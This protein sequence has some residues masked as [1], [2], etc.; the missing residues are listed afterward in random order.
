MIFQLAAH[1]WRSS[2]ASGN[3][4]LQSQAIKVQNKIFEK[5][6]FKWI[7]TVAENSL[8]FEMF[9]IITHF[10]FYIGKLSIKFVFLCILC[11]AQITI[12]R[13]YFFT[14]AFCC[15]CNHKRI[16]AETVI[17]LS[18][19]ICFKALR[20]SLVIVIVRF[21]I[22]LSAI[23]LYLTTHLLV[24]LCNSVAQIAL[25][26]NSVITEQDSAMG[27]NFA[28]YAFCPHGILLGSAFPKPCYYENREV[29]RPKSCCFPVLLYC[30]IGPLSGGA[31]FPSAPLILYRRC[32]LPHRRDRARCSRS[33]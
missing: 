27:P 13:H 30:F 24:Y 29:T 12:T 11:C 20:S 17:S 16:K 22:F 18:S 25:K 5:V 7:I 32:G 2:I 6:T 8:S 19:A 3:Q 4:L 14:S 1:D 28:Y 26:I 31:L 33:R 23:R 15:S 9:T 10:F 21:T